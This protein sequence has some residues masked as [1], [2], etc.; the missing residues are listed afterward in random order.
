MSDILFKCNNCNHQIVVDERASGANVACPD[1]QTELVIPNADIVYDCPKC[2]YELAVGE[3]S[4]GLSLFCPECNEDIKIPISSK[5]VSL[6][7][8]LLG[9][10]GQVSPSSVRAQTICPHCSEPLQV[11]DKMMGK[12]FNCPKCGNKIKI[13]ED[14]E[15]TA[16]S[17]HINTQADSLASASDEE[18]T[19][20]TCPFCKMVLSAPLSTVGEIVDCSK[21]FKAIEIPVPSTRI[22]S[23]KP[24]LQKR[25]PASYCPSCGTEV[26][27]DASFCIKCGADLKTGLN[28]NR[29]GEE[30]K[31][32]VSTFSSEQPKIPHM[33]TSFG[34]FRWLLL[35]GCIIV[36]I[37][38]IKKFNH[39][40]SP[41]QAITT[42]VNH[43]QSNKSS[44]NS[45]QSR[46]AVPKSDSPDRSHAE[47][48]IYRISVWAD[49]SQI[50][51]H[52]IEYKLLV[53]GET[54]RTMEGKSNI[55]EFKHVR[56]KAG[57]VLSAVAY[58]KNGYGATG[59]I[60][61][62]Y[63]RTVT[64]KQYDIDFAANQPE[65]SIKLLYLYKY[66]P[67]P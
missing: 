27:M 65:G 13:E 10:R 57:D 41:Y 8:P 56:L 54:V 45:S 12:K 51:R 7:S 58:W 11:S 24:T 25:G 2:S 36:V 32:D 16:E 21:C 18:Q 60:N 22:K 42:S 4:E 43:S 29:A 66:K 47:S 38:G 28:L 33:G 9:K 23:R 49:Q 3:E 40:S 64:I 31:R 14:A 1:C 52:Y 55:M 46:T 48:A 35:V 63:D 39:Q 26:V 50:P 15:E 44:A 59:E 17:V 30:V 62:S 5:E 34:G 37:V 61:E 67:P 19:E 6:R 20:F 53:N